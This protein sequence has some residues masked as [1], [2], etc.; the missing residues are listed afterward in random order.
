[1]SNPGYEPIVP[2][3]MSEAELNAL[4]DDFRA[5][6]AR[7]AAIGARNARVLAR[8]DQ[9]THYVPGG[10]GQVHPLSIVAE[11]GEN[12]LNELDEPLGQAA[13]AGR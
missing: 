2:A 3:E 1:M 4:Y 10:T 9:P 7:N 8:L 13:P 6:G 11:G 12:E 5:I